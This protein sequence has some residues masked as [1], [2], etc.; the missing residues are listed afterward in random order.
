MY[1]YHSKKF[2]LYV[3]VIPT[4]IELMISLKL[5]IQLYEFHKKPV[6]EDSEEKKAFVTKLMEFGVSIK[7][8]N[9]AF[10]M[11]DITM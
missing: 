2:Y 10:A 3:T 9:D 1:W 8:Y 4:C 5:I 11:K 6:P 7:Q